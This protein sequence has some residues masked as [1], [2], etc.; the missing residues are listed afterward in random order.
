M[1]ESKGHHCSLE[2]KWSAWR[3]RMAEI[4]RWIQGTLKIEK[5]FKSGNAP[6]NDVIFQKKHFFYADV[7]IFAIYAILKRK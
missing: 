4:W 6:Q 7:S 2:K 1:L 5:N 3:G